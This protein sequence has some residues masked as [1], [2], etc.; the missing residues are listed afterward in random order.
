MGFY[1]PAQLIGDAK[2][3]GV[4]VTPV[5]INYSVWDNQLEVLDP[6]RSDINAMFFGIADQLCR[7]V[8]TH[9]HT[10]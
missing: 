10:V 3:H 4:D 6:D 1:Q 2:K 8:K 7:L 9:G 5:D